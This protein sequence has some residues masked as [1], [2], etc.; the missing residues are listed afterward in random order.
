[1]TPHY[2]GID[3]GGTLVKGVLI[4]EEKVV[5]QTTRNTKG[6]KKMWQNTVAEVFWS[7]TEKTTAAIEGIGLSAPGIAD[8]DSR[9]IISMP[10]RLAGLEDFNWSKFLNQN[11]HVI[12]DAHAALIAES[13]WGAAK[14]ESNVVMLTLGTGV[15]GGLL[16]D[17]KL[18]RGFL[19]R[20]GHL[21]HISIDSYSDQQDITGISGSLEDAIGEATLARR[22]LGKFSYTEDLIE[23]Y[24]NGDIWATYVWLTSVRKLSL[25]I[26]SVCN[27][28]SPDLV[29]LA[30]G[31]TGAGELLTNPLYT[32]M[33]L[34]EWRPTGEAT[35][36]KIANFREFS[37][38]LGAALFARSKQL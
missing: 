32:F 7:L 14:Y 23:A 17:G 9:K 29:V 19:Q 33:D 20:A 24:R 11:V 31:I 8:R 27:A 35:P 2:I 10:G 38:A 12:N 34:Y 15:G 16:I 30:G 3:I 28:I 13:T 25:G 37:G 4:D 36:V 5:E 21:G 22:S 1:M 6:G 26:V 18:V